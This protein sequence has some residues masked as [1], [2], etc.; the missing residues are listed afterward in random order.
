MGL[1][2]SSFDRSINMVLSVELS[3]A[4]QLDDARLAVELALRLKFAPKSISGR[5]EDEKY[6]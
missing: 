2:V 4:A 6:S 1:Q 5:R 3:A